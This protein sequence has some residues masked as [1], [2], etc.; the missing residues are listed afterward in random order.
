MTGGTKTPNTVKLSLNRRL[1]RAKCD[2][3]TVFATAVWGAKY[4]FES[5]SRISPGVATNAEGQGIVPDGFDLKT[6]D[7]AQ[8]PCPVFLA[9]VYA[10]MVHVFNQPTLSL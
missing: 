5:F 2:S 6:Q 4:G 10:D 7:V 3:A 9:G 1:R 8:I